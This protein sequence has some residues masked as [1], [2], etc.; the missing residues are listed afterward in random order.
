MLCGCSL[1]HIR[2]FA[3]FVADGGSASDNCGLDET[4][5]SV[6]ETDAGTC[7]RTITRVYEIADSCGNVSTCVQTITIDD[8]TPPSISCPSDLTFEC[9]ADVPAAF[10]T[11]S[12]FIGGGGNASDNCGLDETTF[13]VTETDAGTCPRTITRVYE[14]A[15]SC[16]NVSTCTQTITVDDITPPVITCPADLTFECYADVPAVHT[17][18]ADFVADGGSASDNCGL[19]ETTFSVTETD[20]GS[21]PRTIERTY[22]IED[23]C[24]N[25]STCVQTITVDDITPPTITCPADLTFELLS[26]DCPA[27]IIRHLQIL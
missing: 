9:Y 4:T 27:C 20:N 23:S 25:V 11:Y 18:F 6:T 17:T 22:S 5:F 7:P 13:G 26:S 16:G 8:I 2:S 21:C 3:D 10:T 19:D 24:G 15:D 1:Q 14:I 12:D